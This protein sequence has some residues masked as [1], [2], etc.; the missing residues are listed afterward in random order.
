MVSE[1]VAE[2]E[3]ADGTMWPWG[4]FLDFMSRP[5]TP[6]ASGMDMLMDH[7]RSL[8]GKDEFA[9]D[10]SIVQFKFGS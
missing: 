5:A 4:G 10:F 1:R 3:R 7:V 6:G 9:D 2:I 8:S